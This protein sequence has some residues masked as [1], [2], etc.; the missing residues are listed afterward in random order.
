MT[1]KGLGEML[2]GDSAFKCAV[3]FPLASMI[4]SLQNNFEPSKRKMRDDEI[5]AP[6]ELLRQF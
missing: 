5:L 2:E 1:S 3:K 4:I 6:E